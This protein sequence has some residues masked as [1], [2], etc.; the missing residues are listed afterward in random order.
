MD[1]VAVARRA[2][3]ASLRHDLLTGPSMFDEAITV[4][5]MEVFLHRRFH[6]WNNVMCEVGESDDMAKHGAI[7]VDARGVVLE[8]NP[9]QISGAEFFAQRACQR[10]RHFTLNHDVS[11]FVA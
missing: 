9:V 10:F 11:A 8:I 6:A 5:P 7:R 3:L 1:L 2:L 4:L